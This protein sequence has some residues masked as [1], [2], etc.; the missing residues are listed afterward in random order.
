MKIGKFLIVL[1]LFSGLFVANGCKSIKKLKDEIYLQMA[2]EV[3][4][5]SIRDKSSA[6]YA[7]LSEDGLESLSFALEDDYLVV[8]LLDDGSLSSELAG[9]S[10]SG[11][12]SDLSESAEGEIV[13]LIQMVM[14]EDADLKTLLD[15]THSTGRRLCVNLAGERFV[16]TAQSAG[17]PDRVRKEYLS[18]DSKD[19]SEGEENDALAENSEEEPNPIGEAEPYSGDYPLTV[20]RVKYL[21]RQIPDHGDLEHFNKRLDHSAFSDPFLELM[22]QGYEL[23][24]EIEEQGDLGDLMTYW[25]SG[26]GG[27]DL[28][29]SYSYPHYKIPGL[30]AEVKMFVS[31][32]GGEPDAHT[33][34]LVLQDGEWVIDGFD[35]F[36][37]EIA[38]AVAS[39]REEAASTPADT[40][41][42]AEDAL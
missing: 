19:E 22:R 9:L 16:E 13:G 8:S 35:N 36:G 27:Q 38:S 4:N 34:Y 18:E 31:E 39:S 3:A 12:L 40:L 37:T 5:E 2:V 32:D 10:V 1:A 23:D 20:E 21:I 24:R 26:N 14:R 11:F 6:V 29:I 15:L 7:E 30:K 17:M 42:L 33:I 25:Y 28:K 41:N